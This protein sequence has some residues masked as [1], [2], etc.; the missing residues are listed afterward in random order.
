MRT[1]IIGERISELREQKGITLTELA[2]ILSLQKSAMSYIE[3]GSRLPKADLI[4]KMC[5]YFNVSS[6]YILGLQDVTDNEN[7]SI[8]KNL[9]LSEKAIE[10]LEYYKEE[11][12]DYLISAINLLLEEGYD[13]V[14]NEDEGIYKLTLIEAIANYY[15]VDLSP[16]RDICY[17]IR[18][19]GSLATG[20]DWVKGDFDKDFDSW[21]DMITVK[22]V[23]RNKLV[24]TALIDDVKEAMK[25]LRIKNQEGD[26]DGNDKKEE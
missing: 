18:Q 21:D 15:S 6:D 20:E 14:S 5:D 3:N 25:A 16:E 19:S 12:L 8:N 22:S 17:E 26:P 10:T 24:E 4:V 9:G 23:N 7:L 1:N 13:I 2:N 11:H